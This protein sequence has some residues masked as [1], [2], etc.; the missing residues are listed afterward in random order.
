MRRV[1]DGRRPPRAAGP[2]PGAAALPER[3]LA[4]PRPPTSC[5][6]ISRRGAFA[7]RA[8]KPVSWIDDG[9]KRSGRTL[10]PPF[11]L[12]LAGRRVTAVSAAARRAAPALP[13]S[14]PQR[15]RRRRSRRPSGPGTMQR[16]SAG[17]AQ[18]H[19]S[20]V[21]PSTRPEEG[22]PDRDARQGG[23]RRPPAGPA[24]GPLGRDGCGALPV[25]SHQEGSACGLCSPNAQPPPAPTPPPPPPGVS[26]LCCRAQAP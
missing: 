13:A 6:F 12:R 4:A 20:R 18:T 1:G 9:G 15:S 22:S 2:G 11:Q 23:T 26:G 5:I 8:S 25:P 14:S 19:T 24:A 10:I 21:E 17:P 7:E 16:S 3:P